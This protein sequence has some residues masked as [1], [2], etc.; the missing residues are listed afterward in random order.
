VFYVD[1]KEYE[2]KSKISALLAQSVGGYRY[3]MPHCLL[4]GFKGFSK[5][6]SLIKQLYFK[7]IVNEK[8][9]DALGLDEE[10]IKNAISAI[11]K[12]GYVR[13]Y[14]STVE[15]VAKYIL[16][17]NIKVKAKSVVLEAENVDDRRELISNAFNCDVYSHYGCREFGA[18]ATECSE[19]NG[20]HIN[21]DNVFLEI[22]DN[23]EILV[24]SF[25]NKGTIFIRYKIDDIADEIIWTK[26]RCGDA[27][28]RLINLR[29]RISDMFIKRDGTQVYGD[30]IT[31]SVLPVNSKAIEQ[32]KLIQLDYERFELLLVVKNER[33]AD[34]EAKS[35]I[36][37]L[38]GL[39]PVEQVNVFYVNDI[40]KTP[41][42]K[43]QYIKSL[44]MTYLGY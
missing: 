24:T 9:F 7:Y 3:G 42:G 22:G 13:G 23:K 43:S 12:C 14:T 19:H 31:R 35:I 33:L 27:R 34:I 18:L 38:K 16:N 15:S 41:S 39:M 26:C 40:S 8:R 17:N 1:T 10:E 21:T 5:P 4:W 20:L 25:I 2:I 36:K 32:F 44:V 28:P 11:K 37:N 30:I 6:D 29:G